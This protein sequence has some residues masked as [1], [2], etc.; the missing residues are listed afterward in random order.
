MFTPLFGLVALIATQAPAESWQKSALEITA[1]R[2]QLEQAQ[3]KLAQQRISH[4]QEEQIW[5]AELKQQ[6]LQLEKIRLRQKT[7]AKQ[8][9]AA[10][11]DLAQN[12]SSHDQEK[13]KLSSLLTNL[14][15]QCRQLCFPERRQQQLEKIKNLLDNDD[16]T[17][18]E[19]RYMLSVLLK[20]EQQR[21]HTAEYGQQ[22]VKHQTGRMELLPVINFGDTLFYVRLPDNDYRIFYQTTEGCQNYAPASRE[23]K[24]T[25]EHLFILA[26]QEQLPSIGELV[27]P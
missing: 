13:V 26:V 25:I 20:E 12:K 7:L 3:Q 4:Q 22:L 24:N 14:L 19:V 6:E 27:L 5:Q 2:Q 9:A 11:Q 16:I 21:G 1:A 8:L 15:G 18:T 23:E 17:P 10:Q